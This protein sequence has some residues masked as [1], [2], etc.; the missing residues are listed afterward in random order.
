MKVKTVPLIVPLGIDLD[1]SF[2]SPER[3]APASIPVT[4]EN[5]TPNKINTVTSLG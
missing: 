1:G 2:S 5:S 3:L 4:P